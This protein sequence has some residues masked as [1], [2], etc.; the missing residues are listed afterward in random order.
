LGIVKKIIS[1]AIILSAFSFIGCE[2]P[3]YND[4]VIESEDI[5][6]HIY[7][8]DT[9][10]TE[11][12][13]DTLSSVVFNL[14]LDLEL[15]GNGFY[16]LP[17]DTTKWQT[18]HRLTSVV[19][20]DSVGVNVIKVSWYSNHYW[21]IGDTLG[22]MIENTGSDDLWY[23]GYDTTYITWFNGFEVPVVN[24]ASYSDMHGEVNTMIAPVK[25]MRG[26]TISIGYSYYDDWKLEETVGEFSIVLD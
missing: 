8:S 9:D 11:I 21:L 19:T 26:D 25:T 10:T 17:I 4:I 7:G 24:G 13:E 3:V 20:R 18:L 5:G 22:Y 15:D 14:L 16:H 6:V 2:N 1:T 12:A 23:V